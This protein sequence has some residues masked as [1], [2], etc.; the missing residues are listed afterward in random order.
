MK[1]IEAKVR[2][3][4]DVEGALKSLV[5]LRRAL[6]DTNTEAGT[7]AKGVQTLSERAQER[8]GQEAFGSTR[9]GLQSISQQL[10]LARQQFLA[11]I[12]LQAGLQG[13]RQLLEIADAYASMNARL[14]IATRSQEEFNQAQ[15]LTLQLAQKYQAPL[16]STSTLFTRVL[17]AV[18]PLGGSVKDA[19]VATEALLASLKITGATTAEAS[20]AILQFTQGLGSGVLRG[21]DFN[22]VAEAAPPLL[23]ALALGLGK[24]RDQLKGMAEDGKFTT[25]VIVT[26]LRKGLPQLR[27]DA[28]EVPATIGG[29]IQRVQDAFLRLFGGQAEGSQFVKSLIGLLTGLAE[30]LER[31]LKV[32]TLIGAAIAAIK[33]GAFVGGLEAAGAAVLGAAAAGTVLGNVLRGLLALLGGPIGIVAAVISLAAA[34]GLVESAK[35]KATKRTGN[36]V[37]RELSDA[38]SEL[39][40]ANAETKAASPFQLQQ[41][42][43]ASTEAALKVRRL[44]KE[45]EDL[46]RQAQDDLRLSGGPRGGPALAG[47]R[48][49]LDPRTE[50]DFKKKY[51][52]RRA[53]VKRFAEERVKFELAADRAIEAARLDG[54]PAKAAR[55]VVEKREALAQQAREEAEALEKFDD[56]ATLTRLS[57]YKEFYDKVSEL[58]A[59]ATQRELNLN[60]QLFDLEL[61]SARDYFSERG[62]LETE[63]SDQ[64]IARLQ[65]ELAERKRVDQENRQ[66]LALALKR[67]KANDVA[68]AREAVVESSGGVARTEAEIEKAQRDAAERVRQRGFDETKITQERRDQVAIADEQLRQLRDETTLGDL[69]AQ[70]ERKFREQR[71]REFEETGDTRQTDA[72]IAAETRAAEFARLRE[73]L[74]T[75][76]ET[77]RVAEQA[78]DDQVERGAITS[79][80]AERQKIS[81]REQSI[82]QL[83]E[84]LARLEA[85]AATPAEKNAVAQARLT[86]AGV[87]DVRRELEKVG[88]SEAING[89]NTAL[90]DI[91]TG[92]KTGKAALLD[93]VSSFARAMLNVLNRRLAEALVDQFSKAL[94]SAKGEGGFAGAIASFIA[95]LFHSGGVVGAGGGTRRAVPAGAFAYAPRFHSGGIAGLRAGEV[96]AVLQAGEEVLTAD[97]PRHVRNGGAAG[98]PVIG[99]L[100]VSVAVDSGTAGAD[101]ANA[102]LA[103]SLGRGLRSVV[104]QYVTE[105]LR[106]GGLL[107]SRR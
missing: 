20:S 50:E 103:G 6:K 61:R 73:R 87:R 68:A 84:L 52:S 74:S 41:A 53:I 2:V 90:N 43:L 48:E 104:E 35:T 27:R 9:R 79:A 1:S 18:R 83:D 19:N 11:F 31:V 32:L 47:D 80:E 24:T 29:A 58:A 67:N 100:N 45:L 76:T 44:E 97:D 62:R 102:A 34:W 54:D 94:A 69:R 26:G 98:K 12:G 78:L 82:G 22:A 36:D 37:R 66:V 65:R 40:R 14:R 105:Q 77:Q 15:G 60:Q 39:A 49:L 10:A 88:R 59:D 71:E 3:L 91:A 72:L 99:A 70:A 56:R 28:A 63:A 95:G 107:A 8:G 86:L 64:T 51:E 75:L 30:N 4:G 55:L 17:S 33:I 42:Q 25:S 13:A 101:S 106:P 46:Q 96:P 5:A 92:A 21:E 7:S 81:L 85:V 57:T 38:Q 89:L 16:A 93:M 23:D